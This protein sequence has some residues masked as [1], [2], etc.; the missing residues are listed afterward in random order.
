MMQRVCFSSSARPPMLTF[1]RGACPRQDL[2]RSG[3][4]FLVLSSTFNWNY[5]LRNICQLFFVPFTFVGMD[6][7]SA[8]GSA[9]GFPTLVLEGALVPFTGEWNLEAK[10]SAPCGLIAS[11]CPAPVRLLGRQH[12]EARACVQP[13]PLPQSVAVLFSNLSSF[14]LLSV[15]NINYFRHKVGIKMMKP[16]EEHMSKSL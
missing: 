1:V 11:V 5:P 16:L 6:F 12:G 3:G 8:P 9:G 15:K 10:V 7:I 14:C 2:W 13:L 4:D